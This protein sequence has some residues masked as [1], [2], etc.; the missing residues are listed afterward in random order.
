MRSNQWIILRAVTLIVIS[1]VANFAQSSAPS[2][3]SA[4]TLHNSDVLMMAKRGMKVDAMA[5]RILTSTCNF[6]V[7]PPVLDDLRRRGVPD[8]ILQLMMVVPNGPPTSMGI[9]TGEKPQTSR[10]RLPRGFGIQV[11]TLY[12]VSSADVKKGSTIALTV[13]EPVYIDGAL[14]VAR[15][16]IARARIV[17]VQKARSFGRGG[18]ITWRMEEIRAI[19][20]SSIP[21]QLSSM[22]E[23]NNHGGQ[24]AAGAAAT[25]AIIFPYTAPAAVV[26]AFKKGDDAVVRGSK[27][28]A[29]I[30]TTDMEI[31]GL[32]PDEGRVIYHFAEALKAKTNSAS[33]PTAF[34][35]LAVRN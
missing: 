23:G 26:W 6:D 11:E 27:R 32:V 1:S 28:F 30:T 15:G 9:I 3:K 5:Q 24:L 29:A 4:P 14:V 25:T 17:K 33:T 2:I 35:R 21:V 31:A 10:V 22:A 12:P 34:P 7:F 8:T 13:V 19:D 20:G 16:T 18:A